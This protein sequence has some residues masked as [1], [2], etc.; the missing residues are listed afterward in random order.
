MP[1]PYTA[2]ALTHAPANWAW[3]AEAARALAPHRHVV[4]VSFGSQGERAATADLDD[5]RA[6]ALALAQASALLGVPLGAGQLVAAHR[7]RY[8]Q[9]QPASV[10][11]REAQT[12]AARASV[13]SV[14]GLGV[15]GAWVSGTGLAQVVPDA[16]REAERVRTGL[17]WERR[18]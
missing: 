11:G 3:L 5:H 12:A 18:G 6:A 17:L 8:T 2:K 13:A 15:V 7:E 9:S 1:G 16:L 14:S 4:R 10:M